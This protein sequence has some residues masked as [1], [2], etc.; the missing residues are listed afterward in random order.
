[1]CRHVCLGHRGLHTPLTVPFVKLVSPTLMCIEWDGLRPVIDAFIHLSLQSFA[2]MQVRDF[3]YISDKAYSRADILSCEKTMLEVSWNVHVRFSL[4]SCGCAIWYGSVCMYGVQ[5]LAFLVARCICL[6]QQMLFCILLIKARPPFSGH[7]TSL[8]KLAPMLLSHLG[9]NRPYTCSHPS[10]Q[11]LSYDLTVPTTFSF[12]SR[13][14]KA[15]AVDDSQVIQFAEYLVE[16][17]LVD[18]SMLKHPLSLISAAS[19]HVALEAFG[20]EDTYPRALRRHARYELREVAPVARAL[21]KLAEKA[22]SSSLRAVYKKYSSSK[23]SECWGDAGF[24][25]SWC[26]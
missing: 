22:P 12:L 8:S 14:K 2:R 1:M 13:F 24:G 26:F 9:T 4:A 6:R 17:A 21:L 25:G 15:A 23:F 10:S 3:V 19:L 20:E 16:L 11:V 7:M 18:Y 5:Q